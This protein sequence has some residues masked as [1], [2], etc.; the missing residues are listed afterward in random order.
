MTTARICASNNASKNNVMC[1]GRPHGSQSVL[2]SLSQPG[3]KKEK[4]K[5]EK[6]KHFGLR[7][8]RRSYSITRTET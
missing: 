3:P 7:L 6:G 5:K 8:R 2:A 1:D 4:N